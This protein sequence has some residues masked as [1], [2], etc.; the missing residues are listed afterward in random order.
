MAFVNIRDLTFGYEGGVGNVFEN[1]SFHFNTDWKLGLIGRNG[2]GKTTLLKLLCGKLPYRGNISSSVTMSYFPY[3]VEDKS[4]LSYEILEKVCPNAEDWEIIREL[5]YLEMEAELL[6]RPF[7][8]L[9]GGEQT[10]LLL[11]GLFLN[12][13]NFLLIDEPTNHLDAGSRDTVSAYLK[14]KKGFIIVSH[15]RY[16]LDGCVDHI[17]SINKNGIEIQSGNF[18]SWL[19]NFEKTQAYESVKNERLKKEVTRLSESVRRTSDWSDRAEASKHG[20]ACS[21]LKQDKGYVGHKA[22]KLM[23]RAKVVEAR[24]LQ[25][26]AQKSELL[27]NAEENEP[28]KMFPLAYHSE[29]LLSLSDVQIFYGACKVGSD[30]C[31]ELTQNE[32]IALVGKNGCGKS[33]ILKLIAGQKIDH[34]GMVKIASGLIVSYVPQTVDDIRGNL[35]LFAKE[36][37]LDESLLMAVLSK[38]GLPKKI[39]SEDISSYSQGQKKKV[40]LAAS[41]CCRAHLY[42]WDEPLNYIDIDTRLQI[43]N[44]LCEFRP[45]MIFVEHDRAFRETVATRTLFL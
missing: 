34:R 33:S 29:K 15:D 44:L 45:T 16:F 30:V 8:S 11:A 35:V 25:A 7:S 23:K 38:M 1:L 43:E 32:R 31:L 40:C 22:A 18:S 6:Y 9:S 28:L 41:L 24:Q 21:G 5:S 3:D 2:R 12:E 26:I 4:R 27:R 36:R 13:G 37:N 19:F 10:K 42:I 17:L 20:K 14:K 39:F